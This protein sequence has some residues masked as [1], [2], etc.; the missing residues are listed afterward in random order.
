MSKV[1]K[2]LHTEWSDGWGGQEIRILSESKVFLEK[3]YSVTIACQPDSQLISKANQANIPVFPLRMNKGLNVIAIIKFI[4]FIKKNNIDIVHTHSSVDSRTAG[5]AGRICGIRIVRSRHISNPVGKSYLTWFQYMRLADKVITSGEF[6]RNR[7]IEDNRMLPDKIVSAP[8]GADENRFYKDVKVKDIR[9]EFNISSD[10]F[11]L[12]T[13]SVLRSWKGHSYLIE[14]VDKVKNLIPNIHLLIVGDGPVSNNLKDMVTRL[15]LDNYV[16]FAGHRV[17]PVPF[18]KSM[19]VVV[20][21]SYSGEATSQTLPQAMLMQKP[22]VSTDVGGLPEVVINE[23]T[24]LVVRP[25]DSDS[26]ASV[27]LRLHSDKALRDKLAKNGY[28]HA[29]NLFTFKKMI[30]TTEKVYHDVMSK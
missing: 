16:T 13:V 22:V 15:N 5:I 21:P 12:G 28:K 29:L 2:L 24:G 25:K 27:I 1:I 14:S 7:L 11:V 19:D 26:L 9:I 23:N 6:I 20:L 3:G 10:S 4:Y 8:A 17:D 30:N 18:Y